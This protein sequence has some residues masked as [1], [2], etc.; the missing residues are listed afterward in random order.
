MTWR[1]M[2]GLKDKNLAHSKG[3]YRVTDGIFSRAINLSMGIGEAG[4]GTALGLNTHSSGEEIKQAAE[5]NTGNTSTILIY[6]S[7]LNL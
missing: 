5:Q 3:T 7:Y 1:L 2:R 4:L 6:L